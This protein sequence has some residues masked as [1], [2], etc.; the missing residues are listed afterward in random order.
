M[1]FMVMHI[2]PPAVCVRVREEGW[3]SEGETVA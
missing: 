2:P 3:E 1:N